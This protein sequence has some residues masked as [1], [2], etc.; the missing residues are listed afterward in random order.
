MLCFSD[1]EPG[2]EGP[3]RI[4]KREIEE[5]FAGMFRIN[6]I[7]DGFFASKLHRKGAKAYLSSMRKI[8]GS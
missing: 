8:D 7:K 2:L 5:T 4:S 3:R 6:Y 1:K